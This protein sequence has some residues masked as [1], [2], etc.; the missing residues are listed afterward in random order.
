MSWFER[1]LNW[2]LFFATSLLPFVISLIYV[3]ILFAFMGPT[4]LAIIEGGEPS[5][6]TIISTMLPL[7]L[8]GLVLGLAFTVWIIIAVLWYLRKKARSKWFL[9]L[10]FG[11]GIISF[12][13]AL[14]GMRTIGEVIG[15]LCALAGIIWLYLLE[16][17]STGYDLELIKEPEAGRYQDTTSSYGGIDDRL[18]KE[19]DYTPDKNVLDIAGHR[20]IK[21]V[22]VT[23]D[24]TSVGDVSAAGVAGEET[25]AQEDVVERPVSAE[26]LKLPILLDN[27]GAVIKCLY[28]PGADAVNLCSRCQQ[29]VC[30]KC[31]YITG[32][33]PICRNCW[34]RRAAAPIAP[35]PKKQVSPPSVKPQKQK[36]VEPA[37]PPEQIDMEPIRPPERVDAELT[38]PPEQIVV[39]SIKPSE[40]EVVESVKPVESVA[41]EPVKLPEPE[42]VEPV[43]PEPQK[44]VA[45]LK[46]AKQEAEKGQW[47][48]EFMA[49][50]E[51][52]SPIINV[53]IR[54]GADGM[55]ASPLDLMEGLKL[56]P[57]LERTKKLSKP[58]DKELREAKSEFEQVMSSCI[59]IADAAADF[60]SSGGQAL[61]GGPDFKRIVDGI[62]TANGLME[63]LSQ[64]LA[65]FSHPQG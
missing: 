19:L 64:R 44:F 31:N 23:K 15:N 61:L 63:K 49:L 4:I 48:A 22:E 33:H 60:I 50:Y 59:K 62:E 10:L 46:S 32:T 41:V 20:D 39:E 37:R 28:H 9:M 26:R 12:I 58:K 30:D 13:L 54:R 47:V 18:Y 16:N 6:E 35:P 5:L 57:M 25:P 1:H 11:P 2:S 43:K 40:P 36:V 52:A 21:D 14:F 29:Y 51:Q 65:S 38:K 34:E 8:V 24:T 27:A 56:R 7:F 45:P 3:A 17:R 53:V 55:P 42:Y